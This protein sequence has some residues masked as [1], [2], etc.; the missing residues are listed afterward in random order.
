MG[1]IHRWRK[2][3]YRTYPMWKFWKNLKNK[4]WGMC[5]ICSQPFCRRKLLKQYGCYRAR[6]A[7][8]YL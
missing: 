1:K 4:Y 2:L 6:K 8:G 5:V 7:M 3:K